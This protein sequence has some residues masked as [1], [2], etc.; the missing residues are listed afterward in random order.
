[1]WM[2][3]QS[4]LLHAGQPSSKRITCSY[5]ANLNSVY[6]YS[7]SIS[8]ILACP[9]R[10]LVLRVPTSVCTQVVQT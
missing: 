6:V 2:A 1:M 9:I 8:I 4:G 5:I 7:D 3:K 10:K